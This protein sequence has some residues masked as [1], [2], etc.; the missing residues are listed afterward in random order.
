MAQE[1]HG[2]GKQLLRFAIRSNLSRPGLVLMVVFSVIGALAAVDHAWAVAG[3]L[4]GFAA[5]LA[6]RARF[7]VT[8]SVAAFRAGFQWLEEKVGHGD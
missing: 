1:E 6:I 5:V 8:T 3:I 4:I 7:E 2:G